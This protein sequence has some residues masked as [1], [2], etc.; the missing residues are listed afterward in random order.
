MQEAMLDYYKT[1]SEISN[2]GKYEDFFETLPDSISELCKIVQNTLSHIFWI[3]KKENYGFTPHELVEQGRDPSK[4]LNLRNL[5][6]KLDLYF[7]L[8]SSSFTEKRENINRVVGN[9]R[10]F[11]LLLVSMLRHKG[12]PARVRS[13]AAMYFFPLAQEKHEDHYICEYWNEKQ[14]RWQ[15]V[16]PQLDGLQR[17]VLDLTTDY[18]L[19]LPSEHFLGAGRTW[20]KIRKGGVPPEN[21]GI[22]DWR[23]EMFGLNKLIM[24]LASLNKVEVLAWESWGICGKVENIKKLGYAIFDELAE[25]ISQINKPE[26][27]FELKELFEKDDRYKVPENYKPWFMKFD[28]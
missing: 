21:F 23:G 7:S 20:N 16:D 6:D 11:A 8:D 15:M 25:K 14:S 13:G 22:F 17:K 5:E 3:K 9:C 10:D 1:Q 28:L 2:P 12:T 4:E 27:F 18:T 26:I 24:D 19:D